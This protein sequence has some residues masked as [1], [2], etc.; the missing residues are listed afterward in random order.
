[1]A[2]TVVPLAVQH[3]DRGVV[4][5]SAALTT[6]AGGVVDA[7]SMGQ[8]FGRIV[9]VF[10][11]GGLDASAVITV[12]DGKTGAPLFTYTT[13]TEGTPTR[14]RPSRVVA[15]NAGVA[16]TAGDGSGGAGTG[17]DVNRDIYVAG[18]VKIAVA[19]GGNAETGTLVII[20]DEHGIGD[21]ALAV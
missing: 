20:V 17:N 21:L 12:T 11:D 18:K 4:R 19:S 1:M 8:A 9:A 5:L 10:Y 6:S 7:A 16:I 13:G 2:G 3:R 14:F 15:D